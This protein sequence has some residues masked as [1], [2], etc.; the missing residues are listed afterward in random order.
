MMQLRYLS[1]LVM[2]LLSWS[3]MQVVL[4]NSIS[5]KPEIVTQNQQTAPAVNNAEGLLDA[6]NTSPEQKQKIEVIRKEYQE[7]LRQQQEQL[8]QIQQQLNQLMVNNASESELRQKHDQFMQVREDIGNTQFDLM[9]KMRQ[10]LTP[11]QR[12]QLAE[13]MQQ[14]RLTPPGSNR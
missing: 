10:V 4:A 2:I 13:I 7:K 9:L 5:N 3:P 12:S 6:L 8:R 14:R 11:Q 1:G